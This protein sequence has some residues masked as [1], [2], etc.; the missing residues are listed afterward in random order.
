[1]ALNYGGQWDIIQAV[2]SWV[3]ANPGLAIE[4]LNPEVLESH[5][6]T[7]GLPPPDLLIRTGGES[8]ISNFMLWQLAYSEFYFTPTLWPDFNGDHLD[9]AI[10][11]F[12]QRER[13]FGADV[14]ASNSTVLSQSASRI[15]AGGDK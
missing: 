10:A 14:G 5:M 11:S 9:V 4:S 7:V 15:A 1:M 3:R 2:Q 8:R 6:C 12:H 13:R